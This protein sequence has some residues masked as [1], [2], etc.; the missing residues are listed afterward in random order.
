MFCAQC[1]EELNPGALTCPQC[2]A[3]SGAEDPQAVQAKLTEIQEKALRAAKD[4]GHILR[5]VLTDPVGGLPAGF[6]SLGPARARRA[7]IVLSVAFSMIS[8]VGV[9][10]A[11]GRL[12]GGLLGDAEPHGVVALLKLTVVLLV[13]PAALVG[14]MFL[15]RRVR[16]LK[17]ELSEEVYTTGAAVA[18]LAVALLLSAILGVANVEV[19]VVLSLLAWCYF[20]LILY[21]GLTA[22]G[23][24]S[25]KAAA[26]AVP[27]VVL[28]AAWLAK[29]C[30]AAL[31]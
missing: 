14:A 18:P 20:I 29:I 7:G 23:G 24:L 16:G 15:I 28:V 30:F 26:P 2:G 4:A 27:L 8:A 17:S 19:A 25:S 31:M 1:G 11:A 21:S 9:R 10:I 22:V 3:K 6:A 12:L 5:A 13:P